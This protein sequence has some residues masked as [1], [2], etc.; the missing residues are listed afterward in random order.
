MGKRGLTS[1][2]GGPL[3]GFLLLWLWTAPIRGRSS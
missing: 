2:I 3:A 1:I